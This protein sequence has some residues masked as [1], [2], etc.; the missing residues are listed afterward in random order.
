MTC[1]TVFA[2]ETCVIPGVGILTFPEKIELMPLQVEHGISYQLQVDDNGVWRT[3]QVFFT[4]PFTSIDRKNP[5]N[6]ITKVISIINAVDSLLAYKSTNTR[7]L[8]ETSLNTHAF[9]DEK[10]IIRST[11]Q[12]YTAWAMRTDYYLIN[13]GTNG[14]RI[15]ALICEDGN[16]DYWRPIIANAIAGIQK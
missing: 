15:L 5:K 14:M 8:Q 11:T 10:E 3:A 1:S 7:L 2:A 12:L 16:G 6:D 9:N 13:N 4:Y